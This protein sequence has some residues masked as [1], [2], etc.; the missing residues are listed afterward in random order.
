MSDVI[1][2]R[3]LRERREKSFDHAMD[4]FRTAVWRVLDSF[5]RSITP[6]DVLVGSLF[7][8]I[9]VTVAVLV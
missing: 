8:A 6:T 7:T 1:G 5:E 4:E 3:E 9:V 2:Y